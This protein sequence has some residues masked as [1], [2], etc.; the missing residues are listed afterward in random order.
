MLYLGGVMGTVN[1]GPRTK[2]VVIGKKINDKI[3]VELTVNHS[4]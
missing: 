3:N 1:R 2:R 4:K